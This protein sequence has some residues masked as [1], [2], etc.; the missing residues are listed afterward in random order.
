MARRVEGMITV[1][2][3]KLIY[4]NFGGREDDF[5][6]AGN[7]NFGLVLPPE[8]AETLRAEGWNVK[9][10]PGDEATGRDP[11]F[12]IQVNVGFKGRPPKIVLLTSK[13]RTF[14][15]EDEVEMLDYADIEEVDLVFT[16]YNWEVRGE[17]G[18]KAYLKTMFVRINEDPIELKYADLMSES[19]A[20]D[21]EGE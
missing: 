7:R 4:K 19:S 13:N 21:E 16:P 14:L 5:N 17:R 18:V 9:E 1:E 11:F 10:R 20:Q 3:A 2:D 15:G 12:Y 6:R 8:L